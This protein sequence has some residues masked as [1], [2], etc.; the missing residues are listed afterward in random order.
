MP[1]DTREWISDGGFGTGMLYRPEDPSNF[2]MQRLPGVTQAQIIGL[3]AEDTHL[4]QYLGYTYNQGSSPS[5]VWHTI[6]GVMT[7]N[8]KIERKGQ[9]IIYNAMEMHR[10]TGD[11]NQGRYTG[12]MLAYAQKNGT[13]RLDSAKADKIGTYAFAPKGSPEEFVNTYKAAVAAGYICGIAARLPS[14]FGRE[15]SGNILGWNTYHEFIGHGYRSTPGQFGSAFCK[16]SWG[17]SFG[18]NG[19]FWMPFDLLLWNNYQEGACFI[20]TIMDARDDDLDPLPPPPPPPSPITKRFVVTATA[21]GQGMDTLQ[22][23]GALTASGGGYTGNLGITGVA[24]YDDT[25]PPPSGLTVTGYDPTSVKPGMNFTIIGQGFGGGGNLFVSWRGES[26]V[27]HSRSDTALF[28]RGPASEGT[29]VVVVRVEASEANGPSLT[30]SAGDGPPPDPS[31]LV[32]NALVHGAGLYVTVKDAAGAFVGAAVKAI[33]GTTELMAF[34]KHTGAGIPATFLIGRNHGT[35]QIT[36]TTDDG[37][38]VNGT[39]TV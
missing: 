17:S 20:N 33:V 12:D 7:G 37:Q 32:V 14:V 2:N 39:A 21:T 19:F 4:A 23:G 30:I 13:L 29:A 15:C 22:K 18:D 10:R 16:N 9:E 26:L 11:P 36:A 28:V 27:V 8:E 25:T 31:G 38:T 35:A 6:S 24:V 34:N 3:P 1:N 5:C